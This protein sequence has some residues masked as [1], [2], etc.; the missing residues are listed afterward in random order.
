MANKII[1][2]L[3]LR[4][5]V[6]DDCNFPV[7]DGIQSYRTTSSQI[8]DY[9]RPK[10]KPQSYEI[11]NLQ[12]TTAVGSSALTIAVKTN[13]GTDA[14][15]T[16]KIRAAFRSSTATSGAFVLRE[17]SGALS[18][19]ISSG[20]TLG[21]VSGQASRIWVYLIDNAGT[22]EL[23]ASHSYYA[24]DQLVNT[25]AEGGAGA[26]DSATVIYSTTARTGVAI[27]SIGY[28]DNTQTTAGTWAS[29]G[30]TVHLFPNMA[31]KAP[32][33][34]ILSSGSGTYYTPAGCRYLRVRLVGGGGSGG[35]NSA[36]GAAG[37]P[38]TFGGLTGGGG[39]GGVGGSKS[40][41]GSAS[42]G[43]LNIVGSGGMG[44]GLAGN[45]AGGQG[46]TSAFGGAGSGGEAGQA[47]SSAQAN[48]GSGGGGSSNA[49]DSRSGGASGGYVEKL[50]VNPDASYAY[51]I[52]AGGA[53]GSGGAGA[54]G[55]GVIII[56]EFYL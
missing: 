14:S 50:Y 41:G 8:F 28:I 24:D 38:T 33:I 34:T 12:L 54:G 10:I 56:E 40:T 19:V 13:A 36:D 20:S 26:A 51:A 1:T 32:T 35:S 6:D 55:T 44:G 30:T 21:Q 4:S 17:I 53:A 47:A 49:S 25:T 31:F 11:S 37:G 18:L 48:S 9:I 3:Q 7:D 27:R 42:G 16:D 29:A 2:D 15:S 23:A 45:D 52:G 5:D 46:G 22:P 43:D 39:A